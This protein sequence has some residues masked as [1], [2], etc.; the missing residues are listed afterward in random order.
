FHIL[1]NIPKIGGAIGKKYR[2]N[3]AFLGKNKKHWYF[4]KILDFSKKMWYFIYADFVTE[5]INQQRK[6]YIAVSA[7]SNKINSMRVNLV[8]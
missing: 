7:K 4:L 2:E 1:K 8:Y 6:A 3:S 5:T